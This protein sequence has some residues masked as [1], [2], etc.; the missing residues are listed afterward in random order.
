MEIMVKTGRVVQELDMVKQEWKCTLCEK[1]VLSNGKAR[2]HRRWH[3]KNGDK[4]IR[5]T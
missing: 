2:D 5:R 1:V 4:N 3:G